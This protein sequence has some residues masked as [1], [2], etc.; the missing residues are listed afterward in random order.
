MTRLNRRS[1]VIT[2]ALL[3]LAGPSLAQ[4]AWPNQPVRLVVPLPPGGAADI[5]ER[6]AGRL[7][8]FGEVACAIGL[9]RAAQSSGVP[10]FGQGRVK[11]LRQGRRPRG[12]R[13]GRARCR[14]R[15]SRG[16]RSVW[17]S[18]GRCCGRCDSG[19]R[20][21]RA[22][23]WR[24]RSDDGAVRRG[25]G[26]IV[27]T[28]GLSAAGLPRRGLVGLYVARSFRRLAFVGLS[29]CAR[30]RLWRRCRLHRAVLRKAWNA[31]AKVRRAIPQR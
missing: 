28:R 7:V 18:G 17:R 2:A 8:A 11:R 16:C 5:V 10:S 23:Q 19:R 14:R 29:T 30:Y 13:I 1:L 27:W 12:A 3:G 20:A 4:D 6:V 24:Q 31:H 21:G 9:K 26:G 22:G 15:I 25:G